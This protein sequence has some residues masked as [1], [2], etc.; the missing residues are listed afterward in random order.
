MRWFPVGGGQT[1]MATLG[2]MNIRDIRVDRLEQQLQPDCVGMT[3][4]R[5]EL[6][7][8]QYEQAVKQIP[9]SVKRL[10]LNI[11]DPRDTATPAGMVDLLA[12]L[13]SHQLLSKVRRLCCSRS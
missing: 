9:D 2:R 10:R 13:Q 11:T 7:D 6:A 5:P 1:V 4:F 8:E 12:K 3:N